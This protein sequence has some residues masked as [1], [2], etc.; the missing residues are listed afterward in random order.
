MYNVNKEQ[1]K[2][3]FDPQSKNMYEMLKNIKDSLSE[4]HYELNEVKERIDK[5][6]EKQPQGPK[7]VIFESP[8][9]NLWT[10]IKNRLQS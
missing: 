2:G 1:G 5:I 10:R 4:M 9:N 7:T 3:N 8:K 6:E